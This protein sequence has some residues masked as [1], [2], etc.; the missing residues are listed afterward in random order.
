MLFNFIIKYYL[1]KN[2]L[3][4]PLLK[5]LAYKDKIKVNI[6]LLLLL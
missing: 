2:N 1:S 6:S 4:N 5:I 3:V